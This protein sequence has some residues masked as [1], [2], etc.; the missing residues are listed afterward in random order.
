[1]NHAWGKRIGLAVCMVFLTSTLS[2]ETVILK[3][4]T[5][6]SGRIVRQSSTSIDLVTP[7]G[8][9]SIAKS[10]I[11]RISFDDPEEVKRQEAIKRASDSE[12]SLAKRQEE[13]RRQIADR[14]KAAAEKKQLNELL[15]Q[16]E[17]QRKQIEDLRKMLAD[18]SKEFQ[19]RRL[20]ELAEIGM[21]VWPFV[22]RSAILPGWGQYHKGE[23]ISSRVF[24]TG[25]IVLGIA[26]AILYQQAAASKKAYTS[27][28]ITPLLI[29]R[30]QRSGPTYSEMTSYL[31]MSMLVGS[32]R[33]AAAK[34]RETLQTASAALAVW[35][36]AN[37]FH[38]WFTD[39]PIPAA[40]G[41]DNPVR[42]ALV[43]WSGGKT[44][45]GAAAVL[46]VRF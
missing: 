6:V 11:Q 44:G 23:T 30:D 43:P 40:Q 36:L 25:T 8:P 27:N 21:P 34:D 22:W 35:W 13:L 14:N 1:M 18:Q 9:R 15:Q 32:K 46:E 24:M 33:E 10:E 38:A 45:N 31:T 17:E 16:L 28:V 37:I 4:G 5:L 29:M 3:N 42:F 12:Q 19:E 2:A 7:S 26:D 39:P 41:P 20:K